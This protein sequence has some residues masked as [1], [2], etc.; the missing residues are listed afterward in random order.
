MTLFAVAVACAKI[1]D[2]LLRGAKGDS[3]FVVMGISFSV[4]G[5]LLSLFYAVKFVIDVKNN[6]PD[7]DWLSSFVGWAS[8]SFFIGP[9]LLFA[10]PSEPLWLV[11][12]VAFV[13]LACWWPVVFV[14]RRCC[15]T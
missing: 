8:G 11:I 3:I 1:V 13:W 12:P 5:V 4:I 6:D 10:L 2:D 7:E 14:I 15:S 9:G